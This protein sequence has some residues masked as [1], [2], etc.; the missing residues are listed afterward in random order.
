MSQDRNP[1]QYQAA[2]DAIAEVVR[3]MPDGQRREISEQLGRYTHDFKHLLGSR[4][5][6]QSC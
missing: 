6:M 5:P 3:Q 4:V 2:F 1:E